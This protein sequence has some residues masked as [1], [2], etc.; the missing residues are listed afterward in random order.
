MA[1][2]TQ[3][4]KSFHVPMFTVTDNNFKN[5]LL[6]IAQGYF[7]VERPQYIHF[8][9][10]PHHAKVFRCICIFR[11][12][13]VSN[14]GRT[15]VEAEQLASQDMLNKLQHLYFKQVNTKWIFSTEG[16]IVLPSQILCV[17]DNLKHDQYF[18]VLSL[19]GDAI[20]RYVIAQHLYDHYP[21]F[22]EDMLTLIIAEA[23]REK[24]RAQ[25][26]LNLKLEQY[27]ATTITTRSLASILS[28]VIGK[29]NLLGLDNLAKELIL[30]HYQPFIDYSV[31]IILSSSIISHQFSSAVEIKTSIHNF[32]NELQEYAQKRSLPMPSYHLI[33]KE[34]IDH[35]PMFT[36]N[37]IFRRITK[38]G[39]GATVKS[40]EQM[41]AQSI[42]DNIS[43][44]DVNKERLVRR[45]KTY[46][47]PSAG[48]C[49]AS[50]LELSDLKH[51]LHLPTF[52]TF[53]GLKRAFT[54]PS[55]KAEENYQ[56]LE[57]LGDAILRMLIIDYLLRKYQKIIDKAF[58]SSLV[59]KLVSAETQIIIAKKL[60]LNK[61]ILASTAITDGILSDVLEALIATI[62][63]D[64]KACSIGTVFSFCNSAMSV[65]IAW[66]EPEI[67]RNLDEYN[68]AKD[69]AAFGA[70]DFPALTTISAAPK[71]QA[72]TMAFVSYA[73][74]TAAAKKIQYEIQED[75]PPL[76]SPDWI[77]VK[78]KV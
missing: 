75:L 44:E 57:F 50:K 54:H 6:E 45:S 66:F 18:E 70:V 65:I 64:A 41:A 15:K 56:R 72:S 29:L 76:T 14:I 5:A 49:A 60:Q 58:L 23:M 13:M 31:S 67:M 43:L 42:L 62:Y 39:K 30:D 2:T 48:D 7:G 59:D 71:T 25:F 27:I 34:G 21:E 12:Q 10:G 32:K 1:I 46:A 17:L 38:I 4:I 55:L 47:S 3:E 40:A 19:Y 51:H 35:A 61:Y 8:D 20:L 11:Q 16:S 63:I 37:C 69:G 77:L 22:Q 28:A 78:K 74:V 9:Y 36:V 33:S 73:M 52:V 24:T 26:S 53:T 68:H